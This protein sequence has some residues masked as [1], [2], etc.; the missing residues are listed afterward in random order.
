[1]KR[2]AQVALAVVT[3]TAVGGAGY[4]MMAPDR[5]VA[6]G[7][8]GAVAPSAASCSRSS[9]GSGGSGVHSHGFWSSSD[10]G[11]SSTTTTERGGFG[12]FGRS[13]GGWFAG[14]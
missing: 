3:A 12:S 9:G 1:M 7:S 11:A 10:R 6:A 13:I 8:P 2:S 14:G 4:A 5:C